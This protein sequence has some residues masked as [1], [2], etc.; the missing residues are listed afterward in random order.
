MSI[1][2]VV[3]KLTSENEEYNYIGHTKDLELRLYK[4]LQSRKIH[5]NRMIYDKLYKKEKVMVKVL[6]ECEC[7]KKDILRIENAFIA[8]N[9]CNKSINCNMRRSSVSKTERK[10]EMR[11]RMKIKRNDINYR[12]KEKDYRIQKCLFDKSC[13]NLNKINIL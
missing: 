6:I 8:L 12:K 2:Y 1:K 9:K 10:N 4:H 3:Y 7:E 13:D 11:E 5:P